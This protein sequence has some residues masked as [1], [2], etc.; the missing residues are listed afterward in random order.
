MA[1]VTDKYYELFIEPDIAR[2]NL[3]SYMYEA[4]KAGCTANAEK[5]GKMFNW[6][7]SILADWLAEEH[8]DVRKEVRRARMREMGMDVEED[9]KVPVGIGSTPATGAS[10]QTKDQDSAERQRL[11]RAQ[12]QDEYVRSLLSLSSNLLSSSAITR[13]PASLFTLAKKLEGLTMAK[14]IILLGAPVPSN[15]GKVMIF[16]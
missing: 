14:G 16:K 12:M 6:R 4:Y 9:D 15:D 13:L 1:K 11:E 5:P 2:R 7:G 8:E 10:A 3:L